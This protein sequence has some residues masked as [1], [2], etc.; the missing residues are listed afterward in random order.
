MMR[1]CNFC[2][3]PTLGFWQ[4]LRL[5]LG[6]RIHCKGC[7][8]VMRSHEFYHFALSAFLIFLTIFLLVW[9]GNM[10]GL[11]GIVLAFAV[12][13]IIEVLSVYWIPMCVTKEGHK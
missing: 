2:G 5:G 6:I 10:L 1:K 3:M 11:L 9:L 4:L 13:L 7:G 8:S 12:P